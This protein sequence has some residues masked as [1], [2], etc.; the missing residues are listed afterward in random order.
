MDKSS[1]IIQI[2]QQIAHLTV[3]G[4]YVNPKTNRTSANK[5]LCRCTCGKEITREAF[6]LNPMYNRSCGCMRAK[7]KEKEQKMPY[8]PKFSDLSGQ[9]FG[10]LT[11]VRRT[12]APRDRKKG[13]YFLC[14]CDCGNSVLRQPDKLKSSNNAS[15]GCR[16][17]SKNWSNDDEYKVWNGMKQRCLNPNTPYYE[18]YKNRGICDK[19]LN[20]GN[21]INDMGK[22]PTPQHTL[23]RIDNTKGYSKENCKWATRI[24]QQNNTCTNIFCE[25]NGIKKTLAQW[26]RYYDIPVRLVYSRKS[27]GW[28]IIDAL[29]TP[30]RVFQ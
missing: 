8:T 6:F 13:V 28:S 29:T 21:F 20:Y 15:C 7:K 23:E 18:K 24:E 17:G 3:L 25:I 19:W 22:R 10:H 27:K 26:A 5:Y 2:G 11:A 4:F 30:K 14:I 9:R 16:I 12:D 1:E